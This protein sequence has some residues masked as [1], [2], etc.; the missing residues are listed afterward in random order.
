MVLEPAMRK[1]SSAP[2]NEKKAQFIK[3]L[4]EL[5]PQV[6]DIA[7]RIRVHKETVRYWYHSLLQQGFTV[8]AS[9]D[10]EKLGMKRL[11]MLGC[12]ELNPQRL[13]EE[14]LGH[15]EAPVKNAVIPSG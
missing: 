11:V 13:E 8:Q 3:L 9:Y 2:T 5:G 14:R 7:S 15:G 12:R 4:T 1:V 6:T 10:Y